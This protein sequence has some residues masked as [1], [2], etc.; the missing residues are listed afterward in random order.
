MKIQLTIKTSYLPSW[1]AYEGVREIVQNGRDAEI[2]H[3]AT[4]K[5]DWYNDKLRVENDGATLPLKALLL[6]HTTKLDRSDTIGKF[7]EGLKLGILALVRAGHPVKIRNGSE[8]WTP[9]IERS[10][11]FDE[12][13]LTFIIESGRS[14]KNRVRVEIGGID[15]A[16]WTKFRECFLF[17]SKPTK[18]EAV[19]TGVGTLLL[20]ER[21]KGRV[22]VK[23]IFVQTDPDMRFGYDLR[24]AELDRDRKMV[25]SWNLKYRTRQVLMAALNKEESLFA[26]FTEILANPTTE[27]EG[28]SESYDVYSMP[29]KAAEHVAAD[30]KAKYGEDAVPVAS[31]AES[32]D[33]EHLGKKGIVVPK[34]LGTVLAKTLGDALTVKEALKKEALK[35]YSWH[36]LTEAE[37]ASL[38]EAVEMIQAAGEALALDD[39]EVA[40]F[41]SDDLMGQFSGGKITVA[42]KYLADPDETLRILVHEVAHRQGSDGDKGHVFRIED[43]WKRIVANLR[44]K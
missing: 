37:R 17:I 44:R 4:L 32:K 42:Y 16:A 18:A 27:V 43:I 23:G 1:Q 11:T 31:L 3:G 21:Y 29:T 25:E 38:T 15:K 24:D 5:V 13:V 41:R 14:Y 9:T 19:E 2:E 22:Y 28:I 30:F 36:E 20:G 10:Q 26:D 34:Q 6:G 12:D 33:I 39:I 7:G 40:D 35:S 8:V